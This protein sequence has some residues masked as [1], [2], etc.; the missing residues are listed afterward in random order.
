MPCARYCCSYWECG[1]EHKNNESKHY[2]EDDRMMINVWGGECSRLKGL[3]GIAIKVASLDGI[4]RECFSKEATFEWSP[5]CS[6][7]EGCIKCPQEG[8]SS[9]GSSKCKVPE[10]EITLD[11]GK[12]TKMA[13]M[14]EAGGEGREGGNG[15]RQGHK[16]GEPR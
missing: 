10:G 16:V 2:G 9:I 3:I 5:E 8:V 6:E 12:N 14:M 11:C 15:R 4:L 7:G 13:N 1:G